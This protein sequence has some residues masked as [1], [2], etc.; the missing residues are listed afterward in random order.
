MP[1]GVAA[2]ANK[3]ERIFGWVAVALSVLLGSFLGMFAGGELF[4]EGWGATLAHL[5]QVLVVVILALVAL[6]WPRIGGSLLV[7]AGLAVGATFR[8][9]V[10][11]AFLFAPLIMTGLLYFFGRPTPLRLAYSFVAGIPLAIVALTA[12]AGAVASVQS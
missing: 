8:F 3:R 9:H 7:L 10:S 6:R 12:L 4:T 11:V 1:S 5:A 2:I